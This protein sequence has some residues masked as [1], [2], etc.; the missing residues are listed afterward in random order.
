MLHILLAE[1]TYFW[2]TSQV[3]WMKWGCGVTYT[4]SDWYKMLFLLSFH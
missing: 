4:P 1:K 3:K 2:N